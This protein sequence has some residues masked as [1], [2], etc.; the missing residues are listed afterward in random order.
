MKPKNDTSAVARAYDIESG[1]VLAQFAGHSNV[2]TSVSLVS[3][4]LILTSSADA[5]CRSA[6]KLFSLLF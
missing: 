6:F 3:D 1:D 5:T 2:L 4:E